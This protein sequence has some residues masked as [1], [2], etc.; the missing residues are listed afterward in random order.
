MDGERWRKS[1]EKAAETWRRVDEERACAVIASTPP[2]YSEV[3]R[4]I[5]PTS[6]TNE[7]LRSDLGSVEAPD[8]ER[9]E[10]VAVKQ[11]GGGSFSC[12]LHPPASW[13]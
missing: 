7:G 10:T 12:A 13:A 4:P 5:A 8:R 1:E 9:A 11:I 6:D 3:V 2:R